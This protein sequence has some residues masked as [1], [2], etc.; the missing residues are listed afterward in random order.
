MALRLLCK[1]PNTHL[2]GLS[3]VPLQGGPH[4]TDDVVGWLSCR[5]RT[6]EQW[7]LEVRQ[8]GIKVKLPNDLE[9]TIAAGWSSKAK[10]PIAEEPAMTE[11]G[12]GEHVEVQVVF[13][14][15]TLN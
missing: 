4:K 8:H 11:N 15:R 14:E 7:L 13:D 1:F 10:P 3:W 6:E 5:G 2:S 12:I 9:V